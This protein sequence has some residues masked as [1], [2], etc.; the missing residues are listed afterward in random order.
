MFCDFVSLLYY[1]NG[2]FERITGL[3]EATFLKEVDSY[4]V[5]SNGDSVSGLRAIL[6]GYIHRG[7]RHGSSGFYNIRQVR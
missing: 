6:V 7:F 4:V 5:E 2:I 3:G 1:S